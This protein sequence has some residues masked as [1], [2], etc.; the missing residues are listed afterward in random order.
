MTAVN[1]HQITSLVKQLIT[2]LRDILKAI[3]NANQAQI[4]AITKKVPAADDW[5][6]LAYQMAW[7]QYCHEDTLAQTRTDSTQH[8]LSSSNTALWSP[9]A[10]SRLGTGKWRT[11]HFV[12]A[13]AR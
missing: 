8:T 5:N 1:V 4:D 3:S 2:A 7:T 13:V 10:Q 12:S 6:R 11:L 9:G